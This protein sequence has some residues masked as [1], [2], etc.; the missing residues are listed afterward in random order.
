[1]HTIVGMN[2]KLFWIIPV[3]E[4]FL[5]LSPQPSP[6]KEGQQV[7]SA[8]QIG[9]LDIQNQGITL[10]SISKFAGKWFSYTLKKPG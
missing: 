8:I 6:I 2:L 7:Q 10:E 4:S 1:M 9:I 3:R 5:F